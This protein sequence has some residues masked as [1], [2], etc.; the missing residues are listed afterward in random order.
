MTHDDHAALIEVTGRLDA[1]RAQQSEA[2]EASNWSQFND[3]QAQIDAAEAA[4]AEIIRR[5]S[6]EDVPKL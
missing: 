4:R 1:L 3:V 6:P 2:R 5:T